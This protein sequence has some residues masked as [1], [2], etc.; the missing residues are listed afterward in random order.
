MVNEH[1]IWHGLAK[2]YSSLLQWKDAEVCLGK[3]K[4][5][6]EYSAETLYAEGVMCEKRGEVTEALAAYVNA[7][8]IEPNNVPCKILLGALLSKMGTNMLPA[9][10]TLLSDALRIEPTNRMAWYQLA[11]VHRDDG[12]LSDAAECF[13]AATMLEESDPIESF[14]SIL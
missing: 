2:L 4:D 14:S 8:L 9:A 11:L 12:R 5:L 7:L 10:R 1:D 3:A 13:Q 6:V